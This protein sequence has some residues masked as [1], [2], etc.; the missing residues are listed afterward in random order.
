MTTE[1]TEQDHQTVGSTP[2]FKAVYQAGV[3]DDS[4]SPVAK[5]CA[6]KIFERL[7]AA[8][9]NSEAAAIM[10]K[11][12]AAITMNDHD[13]IVGLADQLKAL[14]LAEENQKQQL[15]SISEEFR[16]EDLLNAYPREVEALAYELSALAMTA[17][18]EEI[19]KLKNPGRIRNRSRSGQP[20]IATKAYIISHQGKSM[21][22]V[23]NVGKPAIPGKERELFNFLGFHVSSDGRTLT[24]GTFTSVN[25]V[26]TIG[27]SKKLIIDDLLAGGS[28]WLD[29]GFSIAEKPA[30][31]GNSEAQAA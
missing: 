30:Q 10:S 20:R 18:Q 9:P 3:D 24:P 22:I 12:Q 26:E 15:L 1:S 29:K 11:M 4:M 8:K 31:D 2:D 21:E 19:T 16:F 14:K 28:Y 6:G 23:P 5:A 25:G 13:E 7:T 27:H 17:A